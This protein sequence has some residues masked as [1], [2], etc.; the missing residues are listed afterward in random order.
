ML[1]WTKL[2]EV[3][4][5]I[6]TQLNPSKLSYAGDDILFYVRFRFSC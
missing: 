5:E 3:V 1:C 2:C 6:E 4:L